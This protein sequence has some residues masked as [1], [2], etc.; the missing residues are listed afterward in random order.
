[1]TLLLEVCVC[2]RLLKVDAAVLLD[3]ILHWK[4]EVL[5]LVAKIGGLVHILIHL[6]KV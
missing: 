5:R 6:I 1:M 4:L 2:C 3:R